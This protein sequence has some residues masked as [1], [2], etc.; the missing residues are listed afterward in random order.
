MRRRAS[1]HEEAQP[2]RPWARKSRSAP[3]NL[4][5]RRR[6]LAPRLTGARSR[7]DAP[8]VAEP[9]VTVVNPAHWLDEHGGIP[10]EPVDLRNRALRVAQC[11]EYGGPLPRGYWRE[12]L[13]PCKRRP[14]GA[15]CPGLMCVLKQSD[16]AIL[17]FA[18]EAWLVVSLL[19]P[20]DVFA[21]G[22]ARL[23]RALH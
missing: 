20:P 4:P 11:I 1:C 3:K 17:A 6:R 23:A 8:C 7:A 2:E 16:D 10:L 22:A 13:I 9:K 18:T 12:T 15:S 5:E 19:P 14:N 21:E